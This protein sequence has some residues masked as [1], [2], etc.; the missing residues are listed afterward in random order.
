M[1][2]SCAGA[3][4]RR[5][6]G[7]G[8]PAE[9]LPEARPDHLSTVHLA[10]RPVRRPEI[11]AVGRS[12]A[13]QMPSG[14]A[15]SVFA[16]GKM[17]LVAVCEGDVREM[18]VERR[19]RREHVVD[20][21]DAS[22]NGSGSTNAPSLVACMC[23]KSITGRTQPAR[24]L[25]STQSSSEP[26]SRTRPITSIPNGTARPFPS[27]RSRTSA[28]CST[29]ASI[30]SSRL[31]PRRKPGWKTTTSAPDAAAIPALRSSAP[32]AD[33]HLRPLAS[34][35]PTQPKRGACTDNATSFSLASSPSRSAHGSP[36]RSDS[37]S[38]PQAS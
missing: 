29:T 13:G 22:R 36:S 33:D 21:L 17:P 15:L 28:S 35:C 20:E 26:R 34:R 5:P 37:K 2:G 38:I 19:D 8:A 18:D 24:R 9:L 6:S 23:A 14:S 4:T 31:R 7:R 10:R 3:A 1:R 11:T 25:I 16:V 27:S 32:S 30:E 12:A